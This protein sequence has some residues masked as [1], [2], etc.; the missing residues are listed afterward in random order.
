MQTSQCNQLTSRRVSRKKPLR[1]PSACAAGPHATSPRTASGRRNSVLTPLAVP[2]G[3]EPFYRP[4][5]HELRHPLIFYYGH[6]AVLY[7]NKVRTRAA[8][9]ARSRP[10]ESTPRPPCKPRCRARSA[11]PHTASMDTSQCTSAPHREPDLALCR[12]HGA[13]PLENMDDLYGVAPPHLCLKKK[14]LL[15]PN[16]F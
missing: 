9:A 1:V 5:Y 6:P 8:L 4:P 16:L 13:L 11:H 12:T 15:Y 2:A 3:E 10:L 7:I 14:C